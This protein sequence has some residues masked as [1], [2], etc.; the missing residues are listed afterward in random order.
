MACK[1]FY[2]LKLISRIKI[3]TYSKFYKNLEKKS[4]KDPRLKYII[5]LEEEEGTLLRRKNRNKQVKS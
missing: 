1:F 2:I 5:N 4:N 3:I